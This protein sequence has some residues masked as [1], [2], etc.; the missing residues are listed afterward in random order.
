MKRFLLLLLIVTSMSL[1][2]Q[3]QL[4]K[5]SLFRAKPGSLLELIDV[6]KKDM[7]LYENNQKVTPYLLRHSQ[8]DHWDLMLIFPIPSLDIYFSMNFSA[9]TMSRNWLEK[10]YG[11]P[12]YDLV[13]FQEEA[14]VKGTETDAF[15]K[16]LEEFNLFH[17]EIFTSLVGKQKEL[18]DQRNAEN[19]FYSEID[20]RSNFIFTR[21]FGPS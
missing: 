3:D 20:H 5:V 15:G 18:L 12:F 6:L 8:G 17:I 1:Q 13:A 7:K 9:S 21:V 14:I 2:A 16:S 10:P 4:Y 11:D 19:I